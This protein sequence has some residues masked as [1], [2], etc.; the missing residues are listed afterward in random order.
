M[1]IVLQG[2]LRHFPAWQ[3]LPF[4]AATMDEATLELEKP[5]LK[6]AL[7]GGRVVAGERADGGEV[8]AVA[9]MLLGTDNGRFRVY[10]GLTLAPSVDLE[11]GLLL[12]DATKYRE[13][14]PAYEDDV[15]FNVVENPAAQ[16]EISL[17]P[18]QLKLLLRVGMGRSFGQLA[19]ELGI[20]RLELSKVVKQLEKHGLL[21]AVEPEPPSVGATGPAAQAG[22]SP[23]PTQTP[24]PPATQTPRKVSGALTA[25]NGAVFAL[26]DDEQTIG[27]IA[28]NSI[29]LEDGSISS[30]HA[31]ITRSDGF[32]SIEDIGSRNGTFVNGE[33]VKEK[34]RLA[35][36]DT[37]RLGKMILVFNLAGEVQSVETTERNMIRR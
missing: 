35:D 24:E 15:R 1:D 18:D 30:R 28:G 26:I 21:E 10:D 31:V 13:E 19:T 37:I 23:A 27:R 8:I 14:R 20:A 6:L 2:S 17:R 11:L 32:F 29:L 16:D 5:P 33:A 36:N 22:E 4:L 7:R 34:R 25:E 12:E 9:A 3:L